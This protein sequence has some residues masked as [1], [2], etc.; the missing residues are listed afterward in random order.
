M[1]HYIPTT[2]IIYNANNRIQL[3]EWDDEYICIFN[4]HTYI[5]INIIL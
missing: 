1:N 4:T 3:I 5:F 2:T